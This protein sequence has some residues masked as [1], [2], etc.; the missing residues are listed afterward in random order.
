MAKIKIPATALD[1]AEHSVFRESGITAAKRRLMEALTRAYGEKQAT[2]LW[3][4][5]GHI[6]AAIRL[7]DQ[8]AL[9]AR[10]ASAA[11]R[12]SDLGICASHS[13]DEIRIPIADAERI[14]AEHDTLTE[15]L[16]AMTD[17]RDR[18]TARANQADRDRGEAEWKLA[19]LRIKLKE[20]AENGGA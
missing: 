13:G 18:E 14:T 20:L 19:K 7:T 2:D 16:A 12:L 17:E 10:G 9:L 1:L 8:E 4:K 3:I 11:A 5:A 15:Q 6:D